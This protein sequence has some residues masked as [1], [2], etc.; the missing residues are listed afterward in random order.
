MKVFLYL[1]TRFS[2][3][4]SFIFT[5]DILSIIM[6]NLQHS[7]IGFPT[8]FSYTQFNFFIEIV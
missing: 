3:P 4:Y 6:L 2:I 1:H 8:P 7:T 5:F